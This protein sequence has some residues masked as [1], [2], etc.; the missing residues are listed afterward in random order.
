MIRINLS[1]ASILSTT[2]MLSEP[3]KIRPYGYTYRI[4]SY[5]AIVSIYSLCHFTTA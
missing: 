4:H 5:A 3:E 2:A 1:R